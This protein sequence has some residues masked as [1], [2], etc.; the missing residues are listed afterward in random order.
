MY[1]VFNKAGG[2]GIGLLKAGDS[3]PSTSPIKN[4][5]KGLDVL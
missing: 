2:R 4:V 3:D 5:L 1:H